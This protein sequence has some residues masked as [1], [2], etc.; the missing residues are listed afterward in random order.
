MNEQQIVYGWHPDENCYPDG[1][2]IGLR[3]AR[4]VL[5]APTQATV[6]GLLCGREPRGEARQVRALRQVRLT[7]ETHDLP[8]LRRQADRAPGSPCMA[9]GF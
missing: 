2:G 7:A 4:R 5:P 8:A 1:T 6:D 3:G 9:G